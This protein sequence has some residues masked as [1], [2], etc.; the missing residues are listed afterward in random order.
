MT[1]TSSGSFAEGQLVMRKW[2]DIDDQNLALFLYTQ[3]CF[4]KKIHLLL[5]AAEGYLANLVHLSSNI[6][7]LS[8]KSH[9]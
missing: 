4:C 8:T 7:I 1:L 3:S 9:L 6:L 5:I 2:A